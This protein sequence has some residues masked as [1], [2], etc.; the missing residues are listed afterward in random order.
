MPALVRIAAITLTASCLAAT[1]AAA[2]AAPSGGTRQPTARPAGGQPTGGT[3]CQV[4]GVWDLVT[5]SINGAPAAP[6][7][8]YHERKIVARGHFMWLGEQLQ[9]DTLPMRTE[10]DSL[11]ALHIDGGSGTYSVSGNG[12]TERLDYFS[13]PRQIGRTVRAVC[14]TEGDRWYHSFRMLGEAVSANNPQILE[15]VWR[16]VR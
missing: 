14:R 3:T 15:E 11:R 7:R 1:H 16:R 9:R 4:E 5:T 13:D 2:Q 10:V 12:Y 8:G 6:R